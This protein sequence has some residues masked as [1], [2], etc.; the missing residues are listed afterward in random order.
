MKTRISQNKK[1]YFILL[2]PLLPP[3]LTSTLENFIHK[4]KYFITNRKVP[5]PSNQH[6]TESLRSST[7]SIQN[8]Y[9]IS[10]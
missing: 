6:V 4:I 1:A 8:Y 9:T 7:I 2:W 5:C 10:S 3:L